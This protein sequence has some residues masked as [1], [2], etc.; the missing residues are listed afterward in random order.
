MVLTEEQVRQVKENL[1]KQVAHLPENER[2]HAESQ[3]DEMSPEIIESGLKQQSQK[4]IFRMI[5]DGDVPSKKVEESGD[6]IAV[7]SKRAVSKGHV[8][9]IPK[10]P[11]LDGKLSK[12]IMKL[13]E[14]VGNRLRKKMKAKDVLIESV[15][16]FGESV[17]DVIPVYD[18]EINRERVYEASEKELDELHEMLREV[19]KVKKKV[20]RIK[21]TK[22]PERFV[23]LKRRIP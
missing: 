7:L 5:V 14:N 3:I 11:V 1:K 22:I 18:K 2:R 13:A 6:A 17:I 16:A 21:K 9:V 4:G 20:I 15:S 10:K 19:K 23:K 12:E 8:L